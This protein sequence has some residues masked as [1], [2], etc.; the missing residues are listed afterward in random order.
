RD[1]LSLDRTDGVSWVFLK[2]Q[3]QSLYQAAQDF[4]A[5][6]Q[7]DGTLQRLTDFYSNGNVFDS[8]GARSFSRDIAKRLPRYQGDF[9]KQSR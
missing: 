8:Y 3:D 2:S 6:K 4:L 1:S 5:R 7:A 9:E